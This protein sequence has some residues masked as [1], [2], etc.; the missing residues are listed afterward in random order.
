MFPHYHLLTNALEV[1]S[2]VRFLG[3]LEYLLPSSDQGFR[4]NALHRQRTKI[5]LSRF[6][7]KLPL[8]ILLLRKV[9]LVACGKARNAESQDD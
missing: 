6:G 9:N 2:A 7:A 1:V 5:S 4:S 8:S 3:S